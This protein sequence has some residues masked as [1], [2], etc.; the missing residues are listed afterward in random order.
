M[1]VFLNRKHQYAGQEEIKAEIND[2]VAR[3]DPRPEKGEVC[4]GGGSP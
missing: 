3:F 1:I 4:R 2:F